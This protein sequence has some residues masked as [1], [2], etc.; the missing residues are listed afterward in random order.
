MVSKMQPRDAKEFVASL[1]RGALSTLRRV[2]GSLDGSGACIAGLRVMEG[3]G[4]CITGVRVDL[5]SRE[6]CLTSSR[7]AGTVTRLRPNINRATT[8]I[9]PFRLQLG[10]GNLINFTFATIDDGHF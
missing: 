4:S 1:Y 3:G 6:C 2:V 7:G 10:L 9:F 8:S 5:K